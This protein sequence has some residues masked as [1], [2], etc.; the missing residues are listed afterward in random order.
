[1]KLELNPTI[2]AQAASGAAPAGKAPEAAAAAPE[3]VAAGVADGI[4]VS[5]VLTALDQTER[6]SRVAAAVQAGSY[7]VSS[8][9][10][11]N[12]IV[13]DALSGRN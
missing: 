8:T 9:A 3:V 11:G 4:L 7:R 12:A 2:V 13:E 6:I 10:T 5:S 1:M